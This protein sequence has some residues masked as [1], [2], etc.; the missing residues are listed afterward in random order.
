MSEAP[1]RPTG[2]R[3][4]IILLL[5]LMSV[6][7]YLDRFCVSFAGDYIKEDLGLSQ[8]Q[9]SWFLSLFFWSYA[10]SQVP[11]GWLADRFGAR[12][13]LSIYVVAWSLFTALMGL[14]A[15]FTML[16]FARLMCGITQAGAYPTA[17]GVI[18]RWVPLS[19]RATAS[20]WVGLGGRIG[21][22]MAP[23]LTAFLMVVFV[24]IETPVEFT[25]ADLLNA[26]KLDKKLWTFDFVGQQEQKFNAATKRIVDIVERNWRDNQGKLPNVG[27]AQAGPVVEP[28]PLLVRLNS[29]LDRSDLFDEAAFAKLNLPREG[30]GYAERLKTGSE[31]SKGE[32]RRFNRL[33]I[34]V[35]FPGEIRKLYG[36]G[37]RPV[38][39]V[40]GLSGVFV[41]LGIWLMFRERPELHSRVND[42]E[43]ALIETGR[44]ATAADPASK[45]GRLPI[46]PL[47]TNFSLWCN[48][49]NQIGTNIGWVFLV[50]W[51]SRYFIEMHSV[52][53]LE[54]SVLVM[55]P[56]LIGLCGGFLGGRWVDWLLPRIGLKWSR[57]L[58]P[59]VTRFVA[60]G[61]YGMC[62]YFASQPAGSALNSP[63]AFTAAFCLI[64]FSVDLGQSAFW[65]YAQDAGGKYV[66]SVLGWGN[67][68]GNLGAAFGPLLY[69]YLLGENPTVA[70]W[71]NL[72]WLGLIAF[73]FAGIAT[74]GLDASKPVF[75]EETN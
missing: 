31:L 52:P 36:R 1:S 27:A 22:A 53:I 11:A 6:L 54:R 55:M 2:V 45:A 72:F 60:A 65:A 19:K 13:M 57:S 46:R 28:E 39:I 75:V 70:E 61:G 44:L 50:T 56:N 58:P 26:T 49:A 24:P 33:L 23:I 4:L 40:Y 34:E 29:L 66:G 73:V 64:Y 48:C 16:L 38:M 74:F 59:I 69:N 20:A 14:A 5:T 15:G 42:A 37:W 62:L 9:M 3:H 35:A 25:D 63:W 68:W 71:N 21:G 43:R 30:L 10:L 67:M 18:S 32:L 17:G 47:F 12:R 8:T 51:L 41:A 7:L